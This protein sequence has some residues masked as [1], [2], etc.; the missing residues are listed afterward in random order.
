MLCSWVN[1]CQLSSSLSAAAVTKLQ[2]SKSVMMHIPERAGIKYF[3]A[4]DTE[5]SPNLVSSSGGHILS[6]RPALG[7]CRGCLGFRG[8]RAGHCWQQSPC[9][10]G[11]PSCSASLGTFKN[12]QKLKEKEKPPFLPMGLIRQLGF[13]C[14]DQGQVAECPAWAVS[15][16]HC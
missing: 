14:T 5:T 11:Q 7:E 16:T 10:Q 8:C 3:I 12:K 15:G 9:S 1:V 2:I 4:S 6:D 13:C